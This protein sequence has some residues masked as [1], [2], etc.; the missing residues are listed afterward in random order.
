MPFANATAIA[1]GG[2]TSNLLDPALLGGRVRIATADFTFATDVVG[3]YT[4]PIRLP[5]GARVICGFL[6]TTVTL[7]STEVA[8]GITGSTG[9][10][11]AAAVFTTTNAFTTFAL[12]AST[13]V[14]LTTEEQIIVTTTAASLPASGTLRMGFLY[15]LD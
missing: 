12:M 10:Y 15:V 1:A 7:G 11:R 6:N 5:I 4:A 8:I 13:G 3:T 14:R 2:T 9:K